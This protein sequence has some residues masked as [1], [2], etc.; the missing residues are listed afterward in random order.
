MKVEIK[1]E[2]PPSRKAPLAAVGSVIA[3]FLAGQHHLIHMLILMMTFGSA[4]MSAL[5]LLRRGM[6]LM[7]LVMVSVTL[8][9]MWRYRRTRTMTMLGGISVALTL[10]LLL[11][12]IAQ[13]GL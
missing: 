3:A 2:A 13:F 7:S 8:W 6:M 4:G 5:P 11:W 9:Q 12:S 1:T 10:G